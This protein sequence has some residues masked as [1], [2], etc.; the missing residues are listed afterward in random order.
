MTPSVLMAKFAA[1]VIN[2]DV[3]H[4]ELQISPRFFEKKM[5]LMLFSGLGGK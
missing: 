1:S 3:V 2:T 4:L 5:T